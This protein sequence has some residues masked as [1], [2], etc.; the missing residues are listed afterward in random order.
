MIG[1]LELKNLK[2]NGTVKN[3]NDLT[4]MIVDG[5]KIKGVGRC[6]K[7][8]VHIQEL[9]LQTRFNT[10]PLDEMDIVLDVE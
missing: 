9:E 4:I 8:S 7:V 6:H 1:K 5:Q 3:K 10:L 2:L